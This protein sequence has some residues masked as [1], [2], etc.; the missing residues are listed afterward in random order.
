MKEVKKNIL[1][2]THLAKNAS[3]GTKTEKARNCCHTS[4]PCDGDAKDLTIDFVRQQFPVRLSFAMTI[5]K[6]QGQTLRRVGLDVSQ[7]PCFSHGHLYVAMS[8]VCS[9]N[10]IKICLPP[11]GDTNLYNCV[12]QEV[13]SAI[14]ESV[15]GIKMKVSKERRNQLKRD[16]RLTEAVYAKAMHE[17][18]ANP[19]E[20][21][22]VVCSPDADGS[23][24]DDKEHEIN[25]R[26][27]K[28]SC[29]NSLDK[30]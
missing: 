6:S 15:G 19:S 7:S 23:P 17:R 8:R 29:S 3:G 12:H 2:C 16:L 22:A 4:L 18:A 20:N 21:P 13:I 10:D 24:I 30:G 11:Q 5:N 25:N 1:V 28:V 26:M 27:W 9:R 14:E